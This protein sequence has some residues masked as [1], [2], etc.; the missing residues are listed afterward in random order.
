MPF[1][2]KMLDIEQKQI[3][4]LRYL[5]QIFRCSIAAG[6]FAGYSGTALGGWHGYS[7]YKI[8]VSGYDADFAAADYIRIFT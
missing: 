6:L 3:H 2:V 7:D 4:K 1:A 8:A 5:Q